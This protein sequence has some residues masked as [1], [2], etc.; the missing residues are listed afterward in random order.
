MKKVSWENGGFWKE[1]DV[2]E[3]NE[4]QKSKA[5]DKEN[6]NQ[7]G[8]GPEV[9]GW[10]NW[11]NGWALWCNKK[12]WENDLSLPLLKRIVKTYCDAVEGAAPQ[13]IDHHCDPN[14]HQSQYGVKE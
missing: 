9:F 11:N 6:R 3:I 7:F 12:W 8:E 4:F 2:L 10:Y 1:D 13:S 5:E 14:P